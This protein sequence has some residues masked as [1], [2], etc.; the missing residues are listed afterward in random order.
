MLPGQY[1]R[2]ELWVG[3]VLSGE[4]PNRRREGGPVAERGAARLSASRPSPSTAET[5]RA[6]VSRREPGTARSPRVGPASQA[7]TDPAR[8]DGKSGPRVAPVR[9]AEVSRA[10]TLHP[11][12]TRA[13]PVAP[14]SAR[15]AFIMGERVIAHCAESQC[16]V[17]KTKNGLLWSPF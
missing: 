11:A 2:G 16:Q 10:A 1:R 15:R 4:R 3:G 7:P 6:A 14:W 12:S 13:M 17:Q 8:T 5:D 9:R